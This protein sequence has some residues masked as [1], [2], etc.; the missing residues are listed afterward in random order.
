MVTSGM[1]IREHNPTTRTVD[2]ADDIVS[3]DEKLQLVDWTRPGTLKGLGQLDAGNLE[4]HD[5]LLKAAIGDEPL[6]AL[7][8][9]T[10]IDSLKGRD[11]WL[12]RALATM[13]HGCPTTL[14]IIAEQIKR[15]RDLDLADCFR[16]EHNIAS[17]CARNADFREG[18]RALLI[19]K[20]M[21]PDWR[22]KTL[23]E[24]PQEYVLSHFE[25][26]LDRHPLEDLGKHSDE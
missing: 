11:E 25:M 23:Q 1:A 5:E 4:A 21:A 10:R 26:P 19:D 13:H 16:M 7:E 20:D 3:L 17:H 12:D 9:V 2:D 6:S 15:V 22:H 18:V 14:G 8:L 24:T